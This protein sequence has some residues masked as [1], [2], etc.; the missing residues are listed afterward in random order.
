MIELNHRTLHHTSPS[1]VTS[2]PH[3]HTTITRRTTTSHTHIHWQSAVAAARSHDPSVGGGSP[4]PC[5]LLEIVKPYAP[6]PIHL[7]AVAAAATSPMRGSSSSSS[8]SSSVAK[9]PAVDPQLQ[10]LDSKSRANMRDIT[11][12][13]PPNSEWG[14]S[15]SKQ[16]VTADMDVSSF[17]VASY[18]AV[19]QSVVAGSPAAQHGIVA[20]TI[21]RHST[22][23]HT[24]TT[25]YCCRHHHMQGE[26][27][28]TAVHPW[29]CCSVR[30]N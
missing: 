24:H 29:V 20:G 25:R 30:C 18:G 22:T 1:H 19:I 14:F 15:L 16:I 17:S 8:S 4:P 2:E 6:P 28:Y 11:I 7:F 21:T 10:W 27:R 12:T 26:R 3:T 9:R 23:S 5:V 13:K